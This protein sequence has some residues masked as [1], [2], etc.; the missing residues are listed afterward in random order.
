MHVRQCSWC[1]H[2]EIKHWGTECLAWPGNVQCG[3]LGFT[4]QELRTPK[5]IA[6]YERLGRERR[7][8]K[9]RGQIGDIEVLDEYSEIRE[10]LAKI[11]ERESAR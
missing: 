5:Q 2:D 9:P 8:G 11:M 6:E 3:C 7:Y 10:H 1:S 4:A